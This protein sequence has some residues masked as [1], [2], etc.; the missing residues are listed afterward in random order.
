MADRGRSLRERFERHG[1]V[2][3]IE[4]SINL[5]AAGSHSTGQ[6]RFRQ[7]RLLHYRSDIVGD[8]A[9]Y[10]KRVDFREDF[11]LM[12]KTL[13]GGSVVFVHF[14]PRR[15]FARFRASSMSAF[16]VV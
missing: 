15:S 8:E 7:G 10:R 1:V 11:V 4:Q 2:F 13:K 6:S 3:G 16:G 9:L 12:Q 5:R 14:L